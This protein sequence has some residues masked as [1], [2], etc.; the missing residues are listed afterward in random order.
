M[1]EMLRCVATVLEVVGGVYADQLQLPSSVRAV[2]GP[3]S[4]RGKDIESGGRWGRT[5]PPAASR[6]SGRGSINDGSGWGRGALSTV[7]GE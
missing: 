5:W 6:E 1:G 2:S 7:Y 4:Q 3:P